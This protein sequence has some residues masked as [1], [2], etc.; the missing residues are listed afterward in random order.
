MK[1]A[2]QGYEGCFHQVAANTYYKKKVDV[3]PCHTFRQLATEVLN[4]NC[5]A[6][7]MAIEN[8]I[9]G[10]ILSNYN[11]LQKNQLQIVGETYLQIQQHLLANHNVTVED[12]KEVHS[13]PMAIQ[14]CFDY[15]DQHKWKIV[16][17]E[18]T[19]LSAKH[20]SH[21]NSIHIA[22]IASSL[23]AEIYDL[24]ILAPDI[25]SIKKNFTRF[26]VVVPNNS[27]N[28]NP[29]SNKASIFFYTEHL[30]GSLAKVLDIIAKAELNLTKIQSV[31]IP[32]SHWDYSFHADMEFDSI[33]QF[34]QAITKLRH[35]TRELKVYGIYKKGKSK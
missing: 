1:I 11:I 4:N 22:A 7:I 21:R 32:G 33:H 18:D 10:S 28:V 6:G 27:Q 8:S 2:I 17:T 34:H 9:A 31:P 12:I 13:H 29:D 19:A 35:I 26:V 24:N 16:E 25:H 20:V 14:Q 15:L 5:D 30:A 3:L 23:A